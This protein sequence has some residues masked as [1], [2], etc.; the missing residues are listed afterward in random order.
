M[1]DMQYHAARTSRRARRNEHVGFISLLKRFLKG[2]AFGLSLVVAGVA[3]AVGIMVL[4]DY[5][6]GHW[7]PSLVWV[8]L[9]V[10][11]ILTFTVLV[12]QFRVSWKLPSFWLSL[13]VLFL[14]HVACYSAALWLLPEWR[15]GWFAVLTPAEV[16]GFGGVLWS[17]G[18][19]PFSEG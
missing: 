14:I 16:S 8:A 4:D 5:S 1:T 18:F 2:L 13:S 3:V 19:S 12:A 11:T 17:I 9:A 6:R 7:L 10:N 15:I